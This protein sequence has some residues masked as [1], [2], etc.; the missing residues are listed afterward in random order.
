LIVRP[1]GITTIHVEAAVAPILHV[2]DDDIR[3]FTFSF[4]HFE[5]FLAK[6]LFKL[7]GIRRW[8]DHKG[9]I[10]VKAAIGGQHM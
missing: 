1:N 8:T 6:Q 9:G 2:L 7:T 3:D 4:E 10:V 5:H